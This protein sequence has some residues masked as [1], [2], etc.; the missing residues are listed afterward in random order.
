MAFGEGFL[1]KAL[2]FDL[3]EFIEEFDGCGFDFYFHFLVYSY[4]SG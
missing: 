1:V 4:I 2:L 3:V